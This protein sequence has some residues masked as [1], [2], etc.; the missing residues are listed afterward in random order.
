MIVPL[1]LFDLR[2]A[3]EALGVTVEELEAI[4]RAPFRQGEELLKRMK[5]RV[6]K[7]YKRLASQLHPDRTGGDPEKTELFTLVTRVAKELSRRTARPD[8]PQLQL[9]P[10]KNAPTSSAKPTM[11]VNIRRVPVPSSG[12]R[13]REMAAKIAKM[14]P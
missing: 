11:R 1:S 5:I 3:Y 6:S 4:E 13:S 7:A 2:R 12:A 14:R 9:A 8:P 10:V